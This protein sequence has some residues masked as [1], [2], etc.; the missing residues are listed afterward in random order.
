MGMS[1]LF[2]DVIRQGAEDEFCV[3]VP[4][5][6]F[7]VVRFAVREHVTLSL[8]PRDAED[9]VAALRTALDVIQGE[10]E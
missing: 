10:Y 7:P 5:D 9:L 1:V 8:S 6:S 4:N 3:V 2:E